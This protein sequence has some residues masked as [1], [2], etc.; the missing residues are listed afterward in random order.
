MTVSGG[1]IHTASS[2]PDNQETSEMKQRRPLIEV[3]RSQK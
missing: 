2:L 3:L 1:G